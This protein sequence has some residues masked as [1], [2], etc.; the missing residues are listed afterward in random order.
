MIRDDI[1]QTIKFVIWVVIIA[2][3]FYI[4]SIFVFFRAGS[5]SRS[6]DRQLEQLA[7]Q[8]TQIKTIQSYYH[9]DRGTN[10]YALGGTDKKGQT[11]YLIYLPHS[12]KAYVYSAKKGSTQ[13]QI[14]TAFKKRHAGAQIKEINLGWY[15]GKPAWEVSYQNSNGNQGYVLYDFKQAKVINEVDNL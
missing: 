7:N 9:L 10:S 15:Q 12:K 3:V 14:R 13:K 4:A 6:N 5:Q 2:I 8:K 1:R 11:F